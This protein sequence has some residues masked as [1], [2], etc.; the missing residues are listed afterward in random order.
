MASPTAFEVHPSTPYQL[1]RNI[2][3]NVLQR[4]TLQLNNPANYASISI[5]AN[6]QQIANSLDIPTAGEQTLRTLVEFETLGTAKITVKANHAALTINSLTLEPVKDLTIPRFNDITAKSGM[7]QV[8]SLKYGGPTIAD[9]DTDGDYDFIVNNHN[10]ASSKLYWN[11]G[12]GTV[13]KHDTNLA[14]WFMHDLHGTSPGDYD[15]DGDLDIIVTQGGGNGINPSKANFYRNNSGNLVLYTGDVGI[16]KGGRGRGA[17]WS[18][19]DL[20]GDLDLLLFNETSLYG[21]KPQHFFYENL[22]NGRFERKT[23]PGIQNVHQ[24][25]VLLTDFNNDGIDDFVFYG[26][27]SL[28][29]GNGDFTFTDVTAK[30][31]EAVAN[32]TGIMAVTDV[33]IDNDGDLD[34]YLARGKA[35]EGG[36]GESPSV[37]FDPAQKVFAIKPRGF[38]GVDTFSFSADGPIEL[39]DYYFLAQGLQRG[40]DYPMFLGRDKQSTVLKIGQNWTL[41]PNQAEGWPGDIS[42]NGMY[43]GYM[44]NGQW[45]AALVRNRDDFWGFKFTLT[46]VTDV[47]TDFT[48]QN[49]NEADI[50]LRNDGD[51]FVN[52]STEWKIPPGTNSLGVTR[53]DFNNDGHQ[54]IFVSRWGKVYGKTSD[55]L[56]LNT[57]QGSFDTV[58]M[59]GAN[60]IGGPGNGDMGQA[61]DFNLDGSLDLLLGNEGGQWYLYQ[62]TA[63]NAGNY[64]LVE[65]GYSPEHHIDPMG[66]YVTL[67]TKDHRYRQRVGSAG[68]IFSQS[69]LNIVHFGLGSQST[70]E[71]VTIAWRNGETVEFSTPKINTRLSSNRLPPT[72]I[73]LGHETLQL[74]T[75]TSYPLQASFSPEH[76][77]TRLKWHSDNPANVSVNQQGV[78]KAVGDAGEY[79]TITAQSPA[80]NLNDSVDITIVDWYPV[81]V[82]SVTIGNNPAPLYTGQKR[83]L[84]A[85]VQPPHADNPRVQWASTNPQVASVNPQGVVTALKSGR[86]TIIAKAEQSD[87]V[88]NSFSLQV[89]DYHEGHLTIQNRERWASQPIVI[90]QPIELQVSYDAGS[91]NQV[92]ASDEGGLRFWLRHFK[93]RWIPVKDITKIDTNVLQ[94]QSGVSKA[95]FNTDVLTPTSDLPA[96]HFYQLR[97]SFTASDGQ[98]YDATI[99]EITLVPKKE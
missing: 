45:K 70:I 29:Q 50:L 37:D 66:A 60:D 89:D 26:P 49:R 8:N 31:P 13:T 52:V 97:V 46:G 87:T 85:I 7:D 62:N 30:A 72:D 2:S 23:V 1:T 34:L 4:L 90:G 18:D 12:D 21:D 15:N 86:T 25:R 40:K 92:I 14:R 80:N 11:N 84:K 56:L 94:T 91:G 55:Y 58:T 16:D 48:P 65:V 79:A 3:D 81:A 24:S 69:L 19:M 64:S 32:L 88:N 17:R 54:D 59:H 93:S 67:H 35:F 98:N 71:K 77:D 78:I 57:G 61:F 73:N 38:K 76:A 82:E 22:G 74:R 41:N 6:N 39:S 42:E 44:G 51:R 96:G 95:S 5:Y 53:G 83:H 75:Q 47:A 68:E 10:D 9:M 63:T 28:W 43:F 20:D 27:L 33:D 36:R 99:D